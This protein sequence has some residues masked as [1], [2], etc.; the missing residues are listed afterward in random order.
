MIGAFV[1]VSTFPDL[2]AAGWQVVYTRS[3]RNYVEIHDTLALLMVT[4]GT[5]T[6]GVLGYLFGRDGFGQAC[7]FSSVWRWRRSYSGCWPR[8]SVW[9]RSGSG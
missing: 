6:G 9:C 7:G 2:F 5:V 8:H 1:G 3:P 4:A